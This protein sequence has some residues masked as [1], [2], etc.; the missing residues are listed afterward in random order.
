V[1]DPIVVDDTDPSPAV[2][3][4]IMGPFPVG[5][6]LVTWTATDASG[7]WAT[8]TQLVTVNDSTAPS[9]MAPADVT[10]FAAGPTPVALGTPV[11]SDLADPSPNAGPSTD[12][13]F[14]IG[15][16]TVTWTATD[17]SGNWATD[18]QVVTV[19]DS[20]SLPPTAPSNL[21]TSVQTSARGK[22]KTKTVTVRWSDNSTNETNFMIERCQESGKGKNKSCS[23]TYLTVGEN[24]T[25]FVESG[26]SGTIKYRVKA[27]NSNGDS[28]W[29]N[30]AKN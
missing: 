21:T 25:S 7:N 8:D 22:T 6:T 18:T 15:T 17:A 14:P 19:E 1:E 2:G 5:A 26:V 20:A 4:D 23:Y 9:I 10:V 24:V 27:Q 12:G 28:A 16:T 3:A 29:S 11:V 30:Q 13:P